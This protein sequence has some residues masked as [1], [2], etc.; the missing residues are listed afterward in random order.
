[1]SLFGL[2]QLAAMVIAIYMLCIWLISL[3]LR[4]V[5]IVDIGWGLGFVVVAWTT[6]WSFRVDAP[7]TW[8]L[9]ALVTLWG[10]RLSAH[11]ASR[12]IGEPED[13][14][15]QA[16]RKKI[17]RSFWWVSLLMVFAL[18][19]LMMWIVS[20]PVVVGLESTQ[21]FP[22][23]TLTNWIGLAVWCVGFAFEAVGDWQLTR[24]K[25]DAQNKGRV[26]NHGLWY[27]TRHP[28]YFGDFCVWWGH[29]F[30]ALGTWGDAWTIVS[31][32]L[33]SVLLMRVSGVSLLERDI[34]DRRP[35]YAE[36]KRRT[37]AFFPW[38]PQE[39]EAA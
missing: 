8:L 15:Y 19:G 2:I 20:L 7:R 35:D 10:L 31:P 6:W 13:R 22:G 29:W 17:G 16:M 30:V 23:L 36:Y 3:P 11:L 28:N 18:Q 33:M 4:D 21:W 9:L 38:P 39:G 24:F 32:L 14:R 1:M 26:L 12:N 25:A 5:S 27:Y 34:T 37:S